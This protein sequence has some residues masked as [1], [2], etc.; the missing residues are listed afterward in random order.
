MTKGTRIELGGADDDTDGFEMPPVSDGMTSEPP[1]SIEPE[2][3][4]RNVKSSVA[5]AVDETGKLTFENVRQLLLH[6]FDLEKEKE[7]YVNAFVRWDMDRFIL[8]RNDLKHKEIESILVSQRFTIGGID[9]LQRR[10]AKGEKWRPVLNPGKMSLEEAY[11]LLFKRFC[12]PE[13][14]GNGHTPV[15]I[16]QQARKINADVVLQDGFGESTART[17]YAIADKQ[18]HM[19][20]REPW[21]QPKIVFICETSEE[22]TPA[23]NLVL[24]QE[25]V[26][27]CSPV[28]DWIKRRLEFDRAFE[29]DHLHHLRYRKQMELNIDRYMDRL[30]SEDPADSMEMQSAREKVLGRMHYPGYALPDGLILSASIEYE[31]T[32]F[33]DVSG[34]SPTEKSPARRILL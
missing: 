25:G 23:E 30:F 19:R 3:D 10:L 14:K 4:I 24:A 32:P 31:K 18:R 2:T 12:F 9:Q 34:I 16:V 6:Y 5:K 13:I 1:I 7:E 20:I 22:S 27:F 11:I 26:K 21:I 28:T 29:L 8:E 17:R 33:I 15:D